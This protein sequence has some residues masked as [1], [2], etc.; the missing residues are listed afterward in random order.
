VLPVF[1]V[2]GIIFVAVGAVLLAA[3]GNV[4]E[5]DI[6]Y[7]NSKQTVEL[8]NDGN[9]KSCAVLLAD[10]SLN[11]TNNNQAYKGTRCQVEHTVEIGS[12]F[13]GKETFLYYGLDSYYQNHR[14]YVDSRSDPQ[15]RMKEEGEATEECDPIEQEVNATRYYAPCGLIANSLFNDTIEIVRCLDDDCVAEEA[16]E[17][18]GS[19]IVRCFVFDRIY[20]DEIRGPHA[21]SLLKRECV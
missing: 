17:L 9:G 18:D 15:L 5:I 2:I 11:Y 14:R 8:D 1:V 3:N 7:T 21:C 4:E 19:G 20:F 16:I 6:E 10:K 12:G 13:E